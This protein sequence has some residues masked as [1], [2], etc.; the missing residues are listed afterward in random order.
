MSTLVCE[1]TLSRTRHTN[2][3]FS[4][5]SNHPL[6]LPS[7]P[8]LPLC[9]FS[10]FFFF[11]CALS[12]TH[13]HLLASFSFS[14]SVVLCSAIHPTLLAIYHS[15]SRGNTLSKAVCLAHHL[16][17]LLHSILPGTVTHTFAAADHRPKHKHRCSP[18]STPHATL[19][20]IPVVSTTFLTILDSLP[21]PKSPSQL[22]SRH[23]IWSNSTIL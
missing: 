12:F 5:V 11:F 23:S 6:A 8:P 14:L 15:R 9:N 3:F 20:S 22:L 18:N 19:G 10:L 16:C 4:P 2:I 17:F 7:A 1:D 21:S 13:P